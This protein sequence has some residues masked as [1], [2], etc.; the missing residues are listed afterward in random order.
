MS[1]KEIALKVEHFYHDEDLDFRISSRKEMRSILK[2]I[3][4]EGTQ[5]ALFYGHIQ[6]FVLTT[7][8]DATERG[9]WLDIGTYPP[10]NKQLILSD[11]ITFVG[12]HKH[13]K[14]Q[15][16]THHIES[17]LFRNES[18]FYMDLPGYLLRI[19]RRE[20]FR[21]VVPAA[22]PIRCIIPIQ[23]GNPEEPVI[24]RAV[25]IVNISG[26]GIGLLCG[27][28]ETMLLPKKIFSNCKI[29]I[30]DIGTLN[31]TIEVRANIKVTAP[32]HAVRT[33]VGCAFVEMDNQTSI[34]LQRYIARLQSESLIKP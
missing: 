34:L 17:A 21:T 3:A 1:H 10:D 25:Q 28:H 11:K 27:E 9:I 24:M 23:P 26:G 2:G 33:H 12:I 32:N 13:V 20:H 31:V 7:L 22:S 15:F 30:P 6:K 5:A 8:L 16:T 19:Q 29:S 4:D 14:I 18:A